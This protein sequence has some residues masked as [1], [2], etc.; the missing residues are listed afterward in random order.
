MGRGVVQFQGWTSGPGW[1]ALQNPLTGIKA[2][3]PLEPLDRSACERVACFPR[4]TRLT[5]KMEL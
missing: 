3:G 4:W 1:S 2:I 5:E